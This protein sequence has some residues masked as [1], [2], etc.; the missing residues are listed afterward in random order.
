MHSPERATASVDFID[1]D[2]I[3]PFT[4]TLK[5]RI[6]KYPPRATDTWD[7]TIMDYRMGEQLGFAW[8]LW[9]TSCRLKTTT[10]CVPFTTNSN[11]K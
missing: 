1:N 8:G 7:G 10:N 2:I 11:P 3:E 6:R 9:V 4:S 5:K